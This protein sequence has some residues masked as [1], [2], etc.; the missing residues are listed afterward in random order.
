MRTEVL[1]W[2]PYRRPLDDD[3]I[4]GEGLIISFRGRSLLRG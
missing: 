2:Q 3:I 4:G 1:V